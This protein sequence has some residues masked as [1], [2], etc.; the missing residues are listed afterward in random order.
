MTQKTTH[1]IS[2]RV[3]TYY[4]GVQGILHQPEHS[5][6]YRIS[7]HNQSEFPIQL[8]D[9]HWLIFDSMGF[10]R[11]VKGEGVVGKQPIIEPNEQ[12]HYISG[13]SLKT[14]MGKMRGSYTMEN[15][16]NKTRFEVEIPEF[17]LIVPHKLN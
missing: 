6:A 14:D 2:I 3:E 9:R 17:E 4:N 15:L 1:G 11:E 10:V 7:I 13:A 16:L 5:F 12:F 8:L